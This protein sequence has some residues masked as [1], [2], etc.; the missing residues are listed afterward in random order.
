MRKLREELPR[1]FPGVTFS[2]PPADIV[3]QILNF[4]S[5]APIELQIRGND[6][7]ANFDY[8]NLLLPKI[9]AITGVADVRIQQSRRKPVFD[10]DVDRTRAQQVGITMRDI[11]KAWSPTLPVAA[12]SLPPSG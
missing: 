7:D 1:Q 2:F 8:A 10:V 12:R 5:P 6:L 11:T 9:R 3:S 4:G